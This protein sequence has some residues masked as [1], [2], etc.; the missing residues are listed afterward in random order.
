MRDQFNRTF[1]VGM[2]ATVKMYMNEKRA[3]SLEN[4]TLIDEYF[5]L[6]SQP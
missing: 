5:I 6:Y 1:R 3:R 4:C 2:I